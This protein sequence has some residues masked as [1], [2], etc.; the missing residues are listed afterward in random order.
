MTWKESPSTTVTEF[1]LS[2]A[3]KTRDRGASSVSFICISAQPA[4]EAEQEDD[5]DCAHGLL[6]T[7]AGKAPPT[8][9]QEPRRVKSRSLT[10]LQKGLSL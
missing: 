5:K 3:T 8:L 7:S 9:V 10:G 4:D 1:E 6:L 2:L